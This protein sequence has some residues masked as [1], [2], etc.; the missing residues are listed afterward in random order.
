VIAVDTNVLVRL[1]VGDDAAQKDRAAALFADAEAI[2]IA[3]TVLLET[4][5]VLMSAYAFPRIEVADA[6][7]RLAGLPNVIVEDAERVAQALGHAQRGV[8]VADALHVASSSGA[9]AFYTFDQRLIRQAVA[10]GLVIAEPPHP[11]G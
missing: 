11:R 6:L 7:G 9:D 5:W 2:F 4:A 1:L 10:Q 8:D 3:K